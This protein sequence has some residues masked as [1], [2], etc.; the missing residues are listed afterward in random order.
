MCFCGRLLCIVSVIDTLRSSVRPYNESV[1]ELCVP[2]H[3]SHSGAHTRPQSRDHFPFIALL[4]HSLWPNCGQL[5]TSHGFQFRFQSMLASPV[6]MNVCFAN[7]R[8]Y[9]FDLVVVAVSAAVG[10]RAQQRH[11]PIE[12]DFRQTDRRLVVMTLQSNERLISARAHSH[13][14][15]SAHILQ[16]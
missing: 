2:T 10:V 14:R 12:I 8:L 15:P 9:E 6:I 13:K 3:R 11:K 7:G 5:H 16:R 4:F 1:H